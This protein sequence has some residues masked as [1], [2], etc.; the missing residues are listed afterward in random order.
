M[1]LNAI[2]CPHCHLRLGLHDCVDDDTQGPSH[3]DG[4]LC[5]HCRNLSIFDTNDTGRLYL[6]KP[7][8][9]ESNELESKPEMKAARKALSRHPQD[10]DSVITEARRLVGNE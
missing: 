1:R 5:A 7:T 9:E 6:R 10:P 4:T 3:G 2:E 8:I